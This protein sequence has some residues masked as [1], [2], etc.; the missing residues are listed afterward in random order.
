MMKGHDQMK[1]LIL[2]N[3]SLFVKKKTS[4]VLE[5]GKGR[6]GMAEKN[7]M[8]TQKMFKKAMQTREQRKL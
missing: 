5:L 6:G 3:T 1:V 7:R 2:T 4:Q 8:E